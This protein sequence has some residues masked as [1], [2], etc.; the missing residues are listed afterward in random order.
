MILKN[1]KNS[2]DYII[3]DSIITNTI[4]DLNNGALKHD[5]SITLQKDTF[6][7][8]IELMFLDLI[9][10][11]YKY[12]NDR[13]NHVT[14]K[15]MD[16]DGSFIVFIEAILNPDNTY[17]Y[18]YSFNENEINKD[19]IIIED[20][21]DLGE[22]M[23]SISYFNGRY[24]IRITSNYNYTVFN[25][26]KLIVIDIVSCFLKNILNAI[27]NCTFDRDSIVIYNLFEID[28]KSKNIKV[29][30]KHLDFFDRIFCKGQTI[31]KF[32]YEW[33]NNKYFEISTN[34]KL[35]NLEY[36]PVS[37]NDL[38]KACDYFE[39]GDYI[40]L[41]RSFPSISLDNI[42]C[43]TEDACL[44][45]VFANGLNIEYVENPTE[46]MCL[47]AVKQCSKSIKYIKNP[48]KN[49]C[50]L[51]VKMSPN[52][53]KYI[54]NPTEEM[55]SIAVNSDPKLI[56]HVNNIDNETALK[57]LKYNHKLFRYI[58][59][60]TEEMCS[61]AV[62]MYPGSIK[63][64]KNQTEEMCLTAVKGDGANIK[65]IKNPTEEMCLT[66]VKGDGA[67]IKYIKNPTEEM[68]LMAIKKNGFNIQYIENPTEEMCLIAVKSYPGSIKYIENQTEEMCLIALQQDSDIFNYI[69]DQTQ[70]IVDTMFYREYN[71]PDHRRKNLFSYIKDEFKTYD[72]CLKA[73]E[74]N[75]KNVPYI[76]LDI[77]D[78]KLVWA[79]LE[80]MGINRTVEDY[81][82]C[83]HNYHY[84]TYKKY[85]EYIPKQ[86][87]TVEMYKLFLNVNLALFEIIPKEILQL[88]N[89][90][91]EY[92]C[93]EELKKSLYSNKNLC[94]KYPA[95]MLKR[96]KIFQKSEIVLLYIMNDNFDFYD[97]KY[98]DCPLYYFKNYLSD[99][100][101]SRYINYIDKAY[102]TEAICKKAV[103]MDIENIYHINVITNDI[104]NYILNS[105]KCTKKICNYILDIDDIQITEDMANKIVDIDPRLAV[106]L[107]DKSE[108]VCMKAIRKNSSLVDKLAKNIPI[109]TLIE[110]KKDKINNLLKKIDVHTKQII[111]QQLLDELE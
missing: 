85:I 61:I 106:S 4:W 48:S 53:I 44:A 75:I 19:S 71:K 109:D 3:Y 28:I 102:H 94:S 22:N 105:K 40:S 41:F 86:Y 23:G 1:Y 31:D 68:C 74:I 45:A 20:F 9:K 72:I 13:H 80:K 107:K 96:L 50:L 60:P 108:E 35:Y 67:N 100:Q 46:E 27:D 110:I 99:E 12:C 82:R 111:L 69:K 39:G 98:C 51:A 33:R 7:N 62:N 17:S 10:S 18:R 25:F 8:L 6:Q 26:K 103:E 54:E 43:P 76:P 84:N 83:Y 97:H 78:E 56:K 81:E 77:Y 79:V 55:C 21:S 89:N 52:N 73:V 104:I 88:N 90:E 49:V 34:H 5:E 29:I 57:V 24:P 2:K 32:Y 92:L 70:K 66:A 11:L 87:I 93:I 15:I 63:Y 30:D 91:L 38:V 59:N 64:V 95:T 37:E 101:K 36:S 14:L 16:D 65:Y 47:T 42:K 58:E